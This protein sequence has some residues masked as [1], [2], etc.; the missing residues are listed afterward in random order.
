MLLVEEIVMLQPTSTTPTTETAA[1]V[2]L[3]MAKLG[4][5]GITIGNAATGEAA[6]LPPQAADLV[7]QVLES[8][9]A[10]RPVTVSENLSELTPNEAAAFLNVSRMHVMKL[11]HDGVLPVRMVGSHHRIPYADLEA[12]KRQERAKQRAAMDRLY[13]LEHETGPV[14]GP[15][16]DRDAFKS[17]GGRDT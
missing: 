2:R 3:I 9:A 17:D 12:Y 4:R 10:G 16:P 15:P 14:D 1:L 6:P 5:D 8:L 11:I 7:R 13:E